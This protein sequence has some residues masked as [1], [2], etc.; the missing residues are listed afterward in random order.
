[1]DF[2]YDIL[3]KQIPEIL[4]FIKETIFI[5][6]FSMLISLILSILISM[7]REYRIIVLSQICNLYVSFF[8]ST[9]LIFQLFLFF[10]GITQM[11]PF[12]RSIRPTTALII[13]MGM[14]ESAFMAETIRGAMSSIDKGQ[15]EAAL[16]IGMTEL[17]S[18]RRIVLPQAIRVALP[19]I[20]NSFIGLI[21]GSSL[22]FTIGVIEIM[23]QAKLVAANSYRMT[24]SYVAV[25]IIYWILITFLNKGQSLIEKR[26]NKGY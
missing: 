23:G 22:G 20:A 11:I 10:F 4:P 5:A 26:L 13:V 15:R 8:R 19:G 24:E 25:L 2:R 6:I 1:M 16:S 14:N 3:I 12:L 21:K 17:Q 7:I 18:M 9:P